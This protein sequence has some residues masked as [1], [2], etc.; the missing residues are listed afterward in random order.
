MY[1]WISIIDPKRVRAGV[2]TTAPSP[3]GLPTATLSNSDVLGKLRQIIAASGDGSV[4]SVSREQ[5]VIEQ[6]R[7]IVNE[8][9]STAITPT[10]D[11]SAT[12]RPDST[13]SPL[14][15]SS[16]PTDNA[17]KAT[18]TQ[19]AS[20]EIRVSKVHKP[21][22]DACNKEFTRTANYQKHLKSK[23]HLKKCPEPAADVDV[24]VDRTSSEQAD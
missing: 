18:P 9:S 1:T 2:A 3:I 17:D 6:I 24:P 16:V 14:I 15:G 11:S 4:S 21:R 22:C 12:S 13:M 10:A 20:T 19:S 7:S 5:N 8:A 23:A